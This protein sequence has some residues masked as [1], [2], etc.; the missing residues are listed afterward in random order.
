VNKVFSRQASEWARQERSGHSNGDLDS[1]GA[2][3]GTLY[4]LL[5][6]NSHLRLFLPTAV[7]S[8]QQIFLFKKNAFSW[9]VAP[10]GVVRI[11]VSEKRVASIFRAQIIR[12]LGA[13][14]FHT[15]VWSTS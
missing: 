3:G 14:V 12:D 6:T 10:C 4:T 13:L 5:F 1:S 11:D 15:V 7:N 8:S 9:D 2:A